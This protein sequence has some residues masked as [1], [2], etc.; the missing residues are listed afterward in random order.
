[1]GFSLVMAIASAS[2]RLL[3]REVAGYPLSSLDGAEE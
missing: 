2:L 1:V 3:S